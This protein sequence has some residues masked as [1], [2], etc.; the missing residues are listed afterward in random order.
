MWLA[1]PLEALN[2][3]SNKSSY[4]RYEMNVTLRPVLRSLIIESLKIENLEYSYLIPI[5]AEMGEYWG[6]TQLISICNVLSRQGKQY[7][8]QIANIHLYLSKN[9]SYLKD[10]YGFNHNISNLHK[11][12]NVETNSQ[13]SEYVKFQNAILELNNSLDVKFDFAHKTS[14]LLDICQIEKINFQPT[15]TDKNHNKLEDQTK[16][17]YI[18][19]QKKNLYNISAKLLIQNVNCINYDNCL[20]LLK[21]FQYFKLWKATSWYPLLTKMTYDQ[22]MVDFAEFFLQLSKLEKKNCQ[23]LMQLIS[24]ESC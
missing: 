1:N 13:H 14:C 22:Q 4:A 24:K 21:T 16:F 3:F 20:Q 2:Y 5:L 23:I 11:N 7:F 8:N 6:D 15:S 17:F 10:K 9:K 18:L 19:N 12:I